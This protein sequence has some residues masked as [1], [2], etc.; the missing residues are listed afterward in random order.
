[1]ALV[2]SAPELKSQVR[3]LEA[4]ARRATRKVSPWIVRL[5]RAGLVA[6]GVVYL[7]IGTLALQAALGGGGALTD[8]EG[9]LRTVLR[10]P[11]G[12]VLLALLSAGLLAYMAWRVVQALTNPER[13]PHDMKGTF[14]RAFRFGSGIIYGA[15]GLAAG[16]LLIGM[17]A[18]DRQPSDWTALVMRQPFGKWL[19]AA[20]GLGIAGYG[21][22][23]LHHAWKG[24][25]KNQLVL[26]RYAARARAWLV[27]IGRAGQAARGVV[28]VIIGGYAFLAGLHTNPR[29]AKGLGEALGVIE[30]APYGPYLL[31]AIA[32]G[33]TAY[34]LFQFIEARYRRIRAD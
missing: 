34:G 19:V 10:Q 28:F 8:R 17:Q 18:D 2:G 32:A 9:A 12:T 1:M 31:A 13:E 24:E 29:E 11:L 23:R 22:V 15:L 30:R 20:A 25:L 5:G 14:K 16:R 4:D 3:T 27:G 6:K 33:L 7:I 21:L 26:D